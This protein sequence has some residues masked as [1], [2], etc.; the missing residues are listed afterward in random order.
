M[1]VVDVAEIYSQYEFR[2]CKGSNFLE[3]RGTRR[4]KNEKDKFTFS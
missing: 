2:Y 1:R 3:A 4:Q